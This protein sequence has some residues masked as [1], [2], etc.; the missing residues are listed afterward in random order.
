MEN[1]SESKV[2]L[3]GLTPYGET[4]KIVAQETL[5]GIG[6]F[7]SR[8]CLPAA[9]E[10]G[11]LL[12]DKVSNWRANNAIK[13]AQKAEKILN[14]KNENDLQGHPKLI[15]NII[16]DGSWTD[17]DVIQDMWAGLL[18]SSCSKDGK[19]EAN[20]IFINTLNQLTKI[21]ILILDYSCKNS[22]KYITNAGWIAANELIIPLKS[23]VEITNIDDLHRLD[24]ELDHLRT[25]NIIGDSGISGGFNSESTDADITPTPFAL[26][27]F[28]RCNGS[29]KSPIEFYDIKK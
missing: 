11:F 12:K 27:M 13:I 9:E 4:I 26:H 7:L 1:K 20:L 15:M 22:N 2:D 10:F 21:E 19:D 23:I 17:D 24:R 14:A 28:A 8:I 29:L 3:F 25:L 6:A 16:N 5:N 18:A